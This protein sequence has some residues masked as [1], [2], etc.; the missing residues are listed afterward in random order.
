MSQTVTP[1][2]FP[3]GFITDAATSLR[4]L[5]LVS[6]DAAQL[7]DSPFDRSAQQRMRS[8]LDHLDQ[9][10]AAA[11]RV[12]RLPLAAGGLSA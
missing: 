9:A 6:T 4:T 1:D 12:S 10:T 2:E 5:E 7:A 8:T 3:E 11:Q